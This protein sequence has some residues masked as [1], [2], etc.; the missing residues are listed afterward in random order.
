MLG[1]GTGD[2]ETRDIETGYIEM[3]D[4]ETVGIERKGK[5][6]ECT[7]LRDF[8]SHCRTPHEHPTCN[9]ILYHKLVL[10]GTCYCHSL[11]YEDNL[12]LGL[13]L[14]RKNFYTSSYPSGM[15]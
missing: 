10:V 7:V 9:Y 2:V 5:M 15:N 6:K 11:E 3:V 14:Y 12:E 8:V 4:I 13:V 1:I